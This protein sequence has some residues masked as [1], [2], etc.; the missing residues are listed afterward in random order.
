MKRL[1]KS[2]CL[3]VLELTKANFRKLLCCVTR[4]KEAGRYGNDSANNK[5]IDF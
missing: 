4:S 1:G 3:A 2:P 5:L